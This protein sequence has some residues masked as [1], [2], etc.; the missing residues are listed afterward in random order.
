M[1]LLSLNYLVPIRLA[2]LIPPGFAHGYLSLSDESIVSYLQTSVYNAAADTGVRFDSFD[3]K[4]P[5]TQPIV[6]ERDL[7]LPMFKKTVLV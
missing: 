5:C 7:S 2:I 6:S 3:F 1:V 4:W